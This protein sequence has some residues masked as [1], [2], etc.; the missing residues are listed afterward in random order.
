MLIEF[1]VVLPKSVT[2]CKSPAAI[3]LSSWLLVTKSLASIAS[4]PLTVPPAAILF[5]I[6]KLSDNSTTPSVTSKFFASKV[7]LPK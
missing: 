1:V 7:A 6:S 4:A 2:C 5:L 3:E